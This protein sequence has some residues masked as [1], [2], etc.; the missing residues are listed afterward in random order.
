[1]NWSSPVARPFRPADA[2]RRAL[3]FAAA[4]AVSLFWAPKVFA[5]SYLDRAALLIAQAAH[6]T[7][8]LRTHLS[9]RELARVVDRVARAR[10]RAAQEME[11][12]KEVAAAHPHLLLVLE[13]YERAVAAVVEGQTGRFLE[14][15]QRARDEEG[16]LRGV[17]KELGW[18]LPKG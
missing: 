12:P 15:Q 14:Y 17:L 5:G 18:T 11:I 10:L 7:D 2:S 1:V 4:L 9:D 8:Y 16:I 13:A 3:C 6:E